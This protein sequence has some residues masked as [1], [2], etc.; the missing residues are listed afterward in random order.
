MRTT[1]ASCF[2]RLTP[3]KVQYTRVM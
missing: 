3:V 1:T 2:D